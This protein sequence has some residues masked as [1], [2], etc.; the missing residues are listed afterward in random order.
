M[1]IEV[2]STTLPVITTNFDIVK[3]GLKAELAKYENVVVTP[4][5]LAE[6]KKLAKEIAAKG[7]AFDAIRKEK[8]AEISQPLVVFGEQMKELTN[9]CGS[10]AETIKS[11]V[12]TFEDEKLKEIGVLLK[13]TLEVMRT[14]AEI[15]FE[16]RLDKAS[17]VFIKLGAITKSG[18]LTKASKDSLAAIVSSEKAVMQTVAL[19]LAQLEAE[20]FKAG[21]EIPLVRLNVEHFLF[22]SDEG[23][24]EKLSTSINSEYERQQAAKARKKALD[25]K[26][27][28]SA[29]SNRQTDATAAK[30]IELRSYQKQAQ[31]NQQPSDG[32]VAYIATATFKL[33]VPKSITEQQITD[34]LQGMMDKA[35]ITSLDSIGVM[36]DA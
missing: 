24:S 12:K 11:Q 17:D 3:A 9:I 26:A 4:E 35:G 15:S 1:D 13:T 36:K 18:A 21:L 31:E 28:E 16:F 29:A 7:K 34:K 5:T 6:D 8:L 25:D 30:K 20:S 2:Q 33:R 23:Y 19:R 32:K 22:D 10:L 14:E 27:I